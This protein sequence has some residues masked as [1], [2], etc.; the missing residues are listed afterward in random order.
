MIYSYTQMKINHKLF[1]SIK[2]C[3]SYKMNKKAISSFKILILN[4]TQTNKFVNKK[5]LLKLYGKKK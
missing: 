3:F 4:Y 5:S 1:I 2:I